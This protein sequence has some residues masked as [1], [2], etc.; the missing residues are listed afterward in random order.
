[1]LRESRSLGEL[2]VLVGLHVELGVVLVVIWVPHLSIVLLV[3]LPWIVTI[4]IRRSVALISIDLLTVLI[5]TI[6]F[7]LLR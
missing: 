2:I 5:L 6:A 4:V 1:M 7:I 3:I